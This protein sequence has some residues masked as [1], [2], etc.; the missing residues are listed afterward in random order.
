MS[1]QLT[2]AVDDG[3]LLQPANPVAS[4]TI[5]VLRASQGAHLKGNMDAS[6]G[7]NSR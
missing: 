1:A 3:W 7:R 5:E 2:W 4:T 6:L